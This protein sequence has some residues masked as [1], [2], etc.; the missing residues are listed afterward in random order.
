MV[1]VLYVRSLRIDR[2]SRHSE[3]SRLWCSRSNWLAARTADHAFQLD[4]LSPTHR[5]ARPPQLPRTAIRDRSVQS[6]LRH[7]AAI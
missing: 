5:T 7:Q 4:G 6:R 3:K 1:A 2:V